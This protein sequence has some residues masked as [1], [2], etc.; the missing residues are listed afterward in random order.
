[1]SK[2]NSKSDNE[3]IPDEKPYVRLQES[4]EI[5]RS[6]QLLSNEEVKYLYKPIGNA[7]YCHATDPTNIINDNILVDKTKTRRYA[8]YDDRLECLVCGKIYARSSVTSHRKTQFHQFHAK[9]QRKF[10][11]IIVNEP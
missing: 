5:G 3:S 4:L 6:I 1:M 10:R 9:A 11:D 2:N 8:R 7:I